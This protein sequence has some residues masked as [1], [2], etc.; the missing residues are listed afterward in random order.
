MKESWKKFLEEGDILYNYMITN[1]ENMFDGD[2]IKYFCV[3]DGIYRCIADTDKIT[4]EHGND[5][6]KELIPWIRK[7]RDEG[8]LFDKT[9]WKPFRNQ[10]MLL[11][12][13]YGYRILFTY[14]EY[15]FQLAVEDYCDFYENNNNRIDDHACFF[16][17][18]Y[19]WKKE[20]SNLL[21]PYR[22][23]IIPEDNIMPEEHWLYQ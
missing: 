18:L 15:I 16:L 9:L 22:D 3:F 21:Q 2:T 7:E 13:Y 23:S 6:E 10:R 5:I 19:G 20:G 11:D 1:F 8:R 14:K 4:E 17:A 12:M